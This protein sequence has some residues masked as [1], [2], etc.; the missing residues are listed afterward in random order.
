MTSKV[1]AV[2]VVARSQWTLS[3]SSEIE[4]WPPDAGD[5]QDAL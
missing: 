2:S 4:E 1:K 3:F 5:L